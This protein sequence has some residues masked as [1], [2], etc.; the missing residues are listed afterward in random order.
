MP[1]DTA[2]DGTVVALIE[3]L[4][5]KESSVRNAAAAS[6]VMLGAPHVLPE[7]RTFFHSS[8][9][10]AANATS[11][12]SAWLIGDTRHRIAVLRVARDVAR[13]TRTKPSPASE[14]SLP[15][16]SLIEPAIREVL[17]AADTEHAEAAT[18]FLAEL[19]RAAPR[20]TCTQLVA[21]CPVGALPPAGILT[22]LG[23]LAQASPAVT[24]I[25]K[26]Q[27]LPRLLP[28]LGAAQGD[29]RIPLGLA[30]HHIA[31]AITS[32]EGAEAASG[33]RA[34]GGAAAFASEVQAGIELIL[35]GWVP[36]R[37]ERVRD[38]AADAIG[39]MVVMLPPPALRALAPRLLPGLLAA[40][41]REREWE[42][43]ALTSAL[44]ATLA[45]AEACNLGKEVHSEQLVLPAVQ[46]LHSAVCRPLD[47][48][49]SACVR[50]HNE[51]LRCL[52]A[53]AA[54]ALEPVLSYL[55]SQLDGDQEVPHLC[56]TI[57]VLRHLV[58]RQRLS[59]W[60]DTRHVA[61]IAAIGG[62]LPAGP[63]RVRL[64]IVQLIGALGTRGALHG[65]GGRPLLM[66]LLRQAALN[67]DDAVGGGGDGMP[68]S[69]WRRDVADGHSVGE[70][71]EASSK[72]LELLATTVP[73]MRPVL[74][75]LLL[76]PLLSD[77][78]VHAAPMVCKIM[79]SIGTHYSQNEPHLL[80]LSIS[81]SSAGGSSSGDGVDGPSSH[82]L[83][84][85]LL[86]FAATLAWIPLLSERALQLLHL[87]A[88]QI[89][90]ALPQLWA[91]HLPKL[92]GYLRS[93][94]PALC[95]AAPRSNGG[96]A[97]PMADGVGSG[98][99]RLGDE[100]CQLCIH[101]TADSLDQIGQTAGG[102]EWLLALGHEMLSQLA[103]P[104]L[105][106]RLKASILGHLGPL[107]ARTPERSL[108]PHAIP[109]MLSSCT[110]SD[111][112]E[113]D[114]CDF[115]PGGVRLGCAMGLGAAASCHFDIVVDA[116]ESALRALAGP[117]PATVADYF[118]SQ[119]TSM[120]AEQRPV[121]AT[122]TDVATAILCL[123]HAAA[124]APPA[125]AAARAE[126][127]VG[128]IVTAAKPAK[129]HV[130]RG[131]A[132]RALELVA[133][134]LTS[135]GGGTNVSGT[136]DDAVDMLLRFLSASL[137]R[138]Y[139]YRQQLAE[140]RRLQLPALH[141]IAQL[142]ALPPRISPK[143]ASAVVQSLLQLMQAD[144]LAAGPRQAA[145]PTSPGRPSSSAGGT[146]KEGDSG[147]LAAAPDEKYRHRQLMGV[148]H[149]TLHSL[150][151][152]HDPPP[153]G[154]FPLLA[155][156]L[157]LGVSSYPVLRFRAMEAGAR[158]LQHQVQLLSE[159]GQLPVASLGTAGTAD[160]GGGRLTVLAAWHAFAA[161]RLSEALGS[162]PLG[163]SS[164]VAA[165]QPPDVS[166]A[167]EESL[168]GDTPSDPF[169]ATIGACI[170]LVLPRC[171]DQEGRI[172]KAA[173]GATQS[174]LQIAVEGRSRAARPAGLAGRAP[175]GRAGEAQT[176]IGTKLEGPMADAT[177]A[178][179]RFADASELHQRVEA[180][181]QLVPCLLEILPPSG[182]DALARSLIGGLDAEWSGAAAACVALDGLLPHANGDASFIKSVLTSLLDVLPRIEI[183]LVRNGAFT[184]GSSLA[185]ANLESV[186]SCL[187]AQRVPLGSAATGLVQ[188]IARDP[189]LIERLLCAL[190]AEI[191]GE[192]ASPNATAND[193]TARAN[194]ATALLCA[195]AEEGL[196]ELD[197]HLPAMLA[198]L[199]LR[200]GTVRGASDRA[201]ATAH[202]AILVLLERVE[203]NVA[204]DAAGGVA[205]GASTAASSAASAAAAAAAAAAA[206]EVANAK[207]TMPLPPGTA[208][209][210]SG[211]SDFVGTEASLIA[212][213]SSADAAA[214][215]RRISVHPLD[216][217]SLV[218]ALRSS[219]SLDG[220][221][222][223]RSLAHSAVCGVC[224]PQAL[225]ERLLPYVTIRGEATRETVV[226]TIAELST[227]ASVDAKFTKQAV[228]ALLGRLA[229]DAPPVRMQALVGL[230]HLGATRALLSHIDSDG[231]ET[232]LNLIAAALA[233]ANVEVSLAAFAAIVPALAT[234]QP[235]FV[236]Q[237][238][239]QL[240][241]HSRAAAEHDDEQLRACGFETFAWLSRTAAAEQTA[242]ARAAFL[243]QLH[244][245]LPL[246]LLHA[247]HANP[248]V[249]R[250]SHVAIRSLEPWF[251][252]KVTLMPSGVPGGPSTSSGALPVGSQWLGGAFTTLVR[253]HPARLS[254][255]TAACAKRVVSGPDAH[256]RSRASTA[257]GALLS[258]ADWERDWVERG[259]DS[260]GTRAHAVQQLVSALK[261]SDAEV[262]EE[263]AKALG[264][265]GGA[266][267]ADF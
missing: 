161:G 58:T 135:S 98:G 222:V 136:R 159:D 153:C 168:V 86:F 241:E 114:P 30:L 112:V 194:A 22:G 64:S 95:D 73:S 176:S 40:Q 43:F 139:E 227:A 117:T 174:L 151:V 6:L 257:L 81:G 118:Y 221:I 65:E 220:V 37:S 163:S 115:E 134:V 27:L 33:E 165:D 113:T 229:D 110:A 201:E 216:L 267:G 74:W 231:Y 41:K 18:N 164:P 228:H 140:A 218:V 1:P 4:A 191:A 97:V 32:H 235:P 198:A 224:P 9:P 62:L 266:P 17:S 36:S 122:E 77:E 182:L 130:L 52:E 105:A 215:S 262:R 88:A 180:Q 145:P 108:L 148:C 261:D 187:L 240:S 61:I 7:I 57:E 247:D 8:A 253:V 13:N 177:R 190:T 157:P 184:V 16:E 226:A 82:A 76:T 244:A 210:A 186:L 217:P 15:A 102:L 29:A 14:S 144:L 111:A 125:V 236:V 12:T 51:E 96:D 195:I 85:R 11:A 178:L 87:L 120:L 2:N 251:G 232:A 264:T 56:G 252:L 172:R 254:R 138:A 60:M 167:G 156:V 209:G 142:I 109:A 46:M 160:L 205:A 207:S 242:A 106:L 119:V 185:T 155:A 133:K 103:S 42:R 256:V 124:H 196:A 68:T 101:F 92:V 94:A 67:D 104:P 131:C 243:E 147:A 223:A 71:K 91:N 99:G 259:E 146:A 258:R 26:Q 38:A 143:T 45:H 188:R 31:R 213:P 214:A 100:W 169:P 255:Y 107:L 204:A 211:A 75:G 19:S 192:T 208:N 10:I 123:G 79:L 83:F 189:A 3:C 44:W 225:F 48:S 72:T 197:A 121:H 246:L 170:G 63:H 55:I 137:R 21:C 193:A 39:S 206:P 212:T 50:N 78:Y 54:L 203:A 90:P 181:Q 175:A 219:T 166:G 154:L 202:R 49:S 162:P 5:D 233:D 69:A 20:E 200:I 199:I 25:L 263:A 89:H 59:S 129:G 70:T 249:S 128:I 149:T 173:C 230:R 238:L 132:A 152:L 93:C 28:L 248:S 126:T 237:L 183:Q 239:A 80:A 84:A 35:A 141:A 265:V 23:D 34:G 260:G 24:P 150:L 53:L 179:V 116:L 66:F 47:R 250:A 171:S 234:A 127:L 158:L 245:V